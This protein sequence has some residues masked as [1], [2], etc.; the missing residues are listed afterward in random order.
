MFN[1]YV[2][3]I[4]HEFMQSLQSRFGLVGAGC[5]D[6]LRAPRGLRRSI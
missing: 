2:Y 4:T 5:L 6:V 3:D 1:L